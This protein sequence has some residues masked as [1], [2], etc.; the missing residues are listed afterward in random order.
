VDRAKR[1]L[2][3]AKAFSTEERSMQLNALADAG[4]SR[5]ERGSVR[6]DIEGC[7]GSRWKL[8]PASKRQA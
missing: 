7:S 5:S 3:S 2:L 4:A 8:E 6:E 1:W